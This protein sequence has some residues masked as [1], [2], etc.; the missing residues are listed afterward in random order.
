MLKQV[1]QKGAYQPY[2]K[3]VMKSETEHFFLGLTKGIDVILKVY[4]LP[5]VCHSSR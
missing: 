3:F 2:G 1:H 4:G 5:G